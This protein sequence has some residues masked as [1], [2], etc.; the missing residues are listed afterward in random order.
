MIGFPQPCWVCVWVERRLLTLQGK[1]AQG[2]HPFSD[3]ER[4]SPRIICQGG[5][6]RHSW[7]KLRP[8]PKERQLK[9]RRVRML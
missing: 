5:W 4:G 8:D 6:G 3:P 7:E 1:G 9:G 2:V